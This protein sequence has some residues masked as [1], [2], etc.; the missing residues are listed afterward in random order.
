MSFHKF[1]YSVDILQKDKSGNL[2]KE[3]ESQTKLI[4]I[5]LKRCI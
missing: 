1:G 2:Q 3:F 4:N 5:K